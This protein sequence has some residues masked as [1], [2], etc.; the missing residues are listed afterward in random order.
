MMRRL[1]CILVLLCAGILGLKAQDYPVSIL[2]GPEL[3]LDS[4]SVHSEKKPVVLPAFLFPSF[5]VIRNRASLVMPDGFETKEQRASRINFRTFNSVMTSID[6]DLYWHRLPKYSE[7][8]NLAFKLASLFLS[9]PFAFPDGCV[10]LMNASFP[11]IYA[12]TPG[13]APYCNPYVTDQ[14]PKCIESEFDFSTGTYK[15]VMVDWSEVQ[16]RMSHSNNGISNQPVPSVPVTP[17]ERMMR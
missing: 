17:V 6:R 13:L 12:K 10:P 1:H 9:N 11:F 15:Q 7:S 16:N 2:D 3:Q 5:P 4:T 14:F 8:W